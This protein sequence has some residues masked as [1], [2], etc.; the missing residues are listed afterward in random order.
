VR[1]ADALEAARRGSFAESMRPRL[2][3]IGDRVH[4]PGRAVTI[5]AGLPG[6]GVDKVFACSSKLSKTRAARRR[7]TAGSVAMS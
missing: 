6:D 2:G 5:R 4:E 7:M 3:R 1:R